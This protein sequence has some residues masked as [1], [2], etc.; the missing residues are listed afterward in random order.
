MF[1]KK[2]IIWTNFGETAGELH[3]TATHVGELLCFRWT[4]EIC[5]PYRE[6]VVNRIV[7]DQYPRWYRL[8]Q[9]GPSLYPRGGSS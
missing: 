1:Y 5:P 2:L 4:A 8:S 9:A 6:V 7:K 3:M